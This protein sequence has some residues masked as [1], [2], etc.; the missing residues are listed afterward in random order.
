MISYQNSA[1][2]PTKD[3]VTLTHVRAHINTHKEEETVRKGVSEGASV[4]EGARKRTQVQR[5]RE[6]VRMRAWELVRLGDLSGR[7][8]V[9]GSGGSR[10]R[11]GCWCCCWT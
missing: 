5:S 2:A 9:L 8:S 1:S 6:N 10:S 7:V 11:G 3:H 4:R